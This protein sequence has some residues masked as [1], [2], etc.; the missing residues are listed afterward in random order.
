MRRP[1]ASEAPEPKISQARSQVRVITCSDLGRESKREL[2]I[3]QNNCP[4]FSINAMKKI[5][6]LI[7]EQE[8]CQGPKKYNSNIANEIVKAEYVVNAHG[9]LI[10]ERTPLRQLKRLKK[11]RTLRQ[12]IKSAISEFI[13]TR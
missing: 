2:G 10:K 6:I 11:K 13:R 1:N 4:Q 9:D 7:L 3:F 12:R 5:N 8:D